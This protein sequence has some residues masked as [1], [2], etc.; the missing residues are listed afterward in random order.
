[1]EAQPQTTPKARP[2]PPPTQVPTTSRTLT[3]PL[4]RSQA[5][6][7]TPVPTSRTASRIGKK[8]RPPCPSSTNLAAAG[9]AAVAALFPDRIPSLTE[10]SAAARAAAQQQQQHPNQPNY[11]ITDGWC[12]IVNLTIDDPE[13]AEALIKGADKQDPTNREMM[14]AMLAAIHSLQLQVTNLAKK[15]A[16]TSSTLGFLTDE[17][18]QIRK[19]VTK[20]QQEA[21][22]IQK[23]PAP[24]PR[25]PKPHPQPYQQG[26]TPPLPASLLREAANLGG[27]AHISN[28]TLA[29]YVQEEQQPQQPPR[30]KTPAPS[31][32]PRIQ[33]DDWVE[34]IGKG[35][36]KAKT[37]AQAAT[38]GPA[39]PQH[40]QH[41]H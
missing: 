39:P 19:G 35:K 27:L 31:S 12:H 18:H 22:R 7:P 20:L 15:Q 16:A 25:P 9:G 2:P 6:S 11:I 4:D 5:S 1:M 38:A 28:Q 32:A 33:A 40:Q 10:Y 34:V 29:Q 3:N 17:T 26:Y 37:F 30:R 14:T 24:A 21:G 13:A 41:K 23:A 8:N 36:A